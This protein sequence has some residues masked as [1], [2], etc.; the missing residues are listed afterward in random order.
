M[1]EVKW[2]E[3]PPPPAAGRPGGL[4]YEDLAA[5]LREQPGDWAAVDADALTRRQLQQVATRI[6]RGD[7]IAFQPKGAFEAL[8]RSLADDRATLFVRFVGE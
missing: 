3:G 2:T 7:I 1:A 6:N 4:D 8:T 5:Q